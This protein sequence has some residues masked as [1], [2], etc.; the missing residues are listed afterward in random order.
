[1]ADRQTAKGKLRTL[2]LTVVGLSYRVT[3]AKMEDIAVDA[4]LQAELVR[5]PDNNHDPNAVKVV[6]IEKPWEN[7]H[8][9]YLSRE[10]AKEL[11]PRLDGGMEIA[12]AWLLS[13]D[14]IESKGELTVKVR[15]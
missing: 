13:V 5:E 3:P 14:L 6:L 2:D 7:F 11:A 1:M 12:E 15:K 9:G 10:V 4:P 8:I